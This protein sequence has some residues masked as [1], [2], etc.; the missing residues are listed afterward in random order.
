[1]KSVCPS[2]F[3][4]KSGHHQFYRS[5]PVQCNENCENKKVA[6]NIREAECD[7]EE[8][9]HDGGDCTKEMDFAKKSSF[10][11]RRSFYKASLDFN[12][13]LLNKNFNPK[14]RRMVP[15]MPL[16]RVI[17][18]KFIKSL[19]ANDS[20]LDL[21]YRILNQKF[22]GNNPT[23]DLQQ[24]YFEKDGRKLQSSMGKFKPDEVPV[25]RKSSICLLLP[26]LCLGIVFFASRNNHSQ[27]NYPRQRV[28]IPL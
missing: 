18:G 26:K 13:F 3:I 12:N 11:D 28:Q 8:C 17:L 4:S 16:I 14:N 25:K 2:N 6:N 1:M 27:Q 21:R 5:M 9:Y 23:Y 7:T 20:L 15:H 22:S 19:P 10:V 24:I